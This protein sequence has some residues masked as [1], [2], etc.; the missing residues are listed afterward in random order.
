MEK[1][2]KF[3]Q[4]MTIITIIA[5]VLCYLAYYKNVYDQKSAEAAI[6]NQ[7]TDVVL[8]KKNF[9]VFEKRFKNVKCTFS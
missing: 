2:K 7:K 1:T 8:R 5:S 9:F 3:L 6:K 4:L